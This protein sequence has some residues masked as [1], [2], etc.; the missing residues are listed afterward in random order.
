MK[1]MALLILAVFV[2]VLC[3]PAKT[4][5]ITRVQMWLLA[6]VALVSAGLAATLALGGY[7]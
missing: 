3:Q 5:P 2:G 4:R 7:V 6:A 1:I